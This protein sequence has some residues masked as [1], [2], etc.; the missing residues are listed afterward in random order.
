M[1]ALNGYSPLIYDLQ[2]ETSYEDYVTHVKRVLVSLDENNDI[3]K[4]LVS[5]HS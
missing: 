1:T 2:P 5:Y 4:D 3:T